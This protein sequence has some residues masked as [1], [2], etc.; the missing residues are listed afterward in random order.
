MAAIAGLLGINSTDSQLIYTNTIGQAAIYDAVNEYLARW[1]QEITQIT[2][3]FIQGET[4]NYSERYMLPAGGYLQRRGI[5]ATPAAM[6]ATGSW[7]CGYPLEDFGTVV[8]G[9]DVSLAYMSIADLD[10]H[11]SGVIAQDINTVRFEILKC[12][13][14]SSG[15]TVTDELFGSITVQPLAN[16]DSVVYP[17]VQGTVTEATANYYAESGYAA[18]SISD[19]NNPFETVSAILK[20]RHGSPTGGVPIFAFHNPAQ[21]AKIKALTNF[22]PYVDARIIPSTA[23]N[24]LDPISVPP[25]TPGE[26]IGITD[27]CVNI[28]WDW[29]PANYILFLHTG[30]PAPL[31]MRVDLARTGLPRGLQLV[32]TSDAAPLVHSFYRHRFGVGTANRLAAYVLELGT[33]GSYTIPTAYA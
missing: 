21:N 33:G 2:G 15:R 9:S 18:S 22:T 10:R 25:N 30:V 31:K 12:L 32:K 19:S 5:Q 17:P 26:V 23:A 3:L 14:N 8:G 13:F 4:E 6:K 24:R 20:T 7:D 28:S 29:I 11:V 1:S 16:G 27:S